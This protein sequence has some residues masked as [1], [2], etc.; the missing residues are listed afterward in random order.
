MASKSWI[1][2][3]FKNVCIIYIRNLHKEIKSIYNNSRVYTI[4]LTVTYLFI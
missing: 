1:I 2:W 3:D 4:I